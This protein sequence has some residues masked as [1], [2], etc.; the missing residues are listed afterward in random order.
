MTGEPSPSVGTE[1]CPLAADPW[2]HRLSTAER[3]SR[4]GAARAAGA[5][6]ARDVAQRWG[7][8]PEAIAQR[9]GIPIREDAGSADYG[10]VRVFAEYGTTPPRIVLY[11]AA[12]AA[13]DAWLAR[14]GNGARVGETSARRIFVAHELFHHFDLTGDAPPLARRWPVTILAVGPLRW[15]T[16]LPALAEI[17]ASAFAQTLLGLRLSPDE[18]ARRAVADD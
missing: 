17:G 4:V 18:V 5:V 13:V 3:G 10:S 6:L 1:G 8:D 9:V 15:T 11:P 16:G 12:I 14:P 7:I 2:A